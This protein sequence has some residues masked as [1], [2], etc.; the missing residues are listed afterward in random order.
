MKGCHESIRGVFPILA[1]LATFRLCLAALTTAKSTLFG[2][3]AGE[4][5]NYPRKVL[6]GGSLKI[7]TTPEKCTFRVV[8]ICLA[9]VK[10]K[11]GGVCKKAKIGKS[12]FRGRGHPQSALFGPR[13]KS[14]LFG[15]CHEKYHFL[16]QSVRWQQW[17]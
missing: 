4:N 7:Q 8:W 12:L 17:F 3:L 13:P 10:L 11:F 5:P 9:S 6:F 14:A 16:F 15:P 2:Q 1:F